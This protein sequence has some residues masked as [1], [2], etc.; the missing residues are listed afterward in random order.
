MPGL[1]VERYDP[2]TVAIVRDDPVEEALQPPAARAEPDTV[3][4]AI[5]SEAP[6]DDVVAAPEDS[7]VR[8]DGEVVAAMSVDDI[9]PS[10]PAS[11]K[12]KRTSTLVN[13]LLYSLLIV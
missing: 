9:A 5:K 7:A 6:M 13:I 12:R 10:K 11:A 2:F 1:L 4:P 8:V 3:E